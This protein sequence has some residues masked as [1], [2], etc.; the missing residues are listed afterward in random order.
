MNAVEE[1]RYWLEQAKLQFD[2]ASSH[3]KLG[4]DMV[5]VSRRLLEEEGSD[6]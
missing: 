2:K 4:A 3:I 5:E 1:S 6:A